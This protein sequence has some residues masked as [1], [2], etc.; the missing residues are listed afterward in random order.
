[1]HTKSKKKEEKNESET[2]F[3]NDHIFGLCCFILE[4]LINKNYGDSRITEYELYK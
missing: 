1:M 2:T 3:F 4:V